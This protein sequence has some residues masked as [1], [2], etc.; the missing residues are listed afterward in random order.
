MTTAPT[1][2]DQHGAVL[3]GVYVPRH[4]SRRYVL[5]TAI[6]YAGGEQNPNGWGSYS[7][8]ALSGSDCGSGPSVNSMNLPERWRLAEDQSLVC[9]GKEALRRKRRILDYSQHR[10]HM[11]SSTK[12]HQAWAVLTAGPEGRIDRHPP[13][14]AT[15]EWTSADTEEIM[16]AGRQKA[17]AIEI[18]P[19]GPSPFGSHRVEPSGLSGE[20]DPAVDRGQTGT[21]MAPQTQTAKE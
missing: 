3:G 13:H 6:Y 18:I 2:P 4:G 10:P 11:G 12:D 5:V 21:T 8:L 17:P 15:E 1:A 14:M 20:L 9:T 16:E 7:L 19:F